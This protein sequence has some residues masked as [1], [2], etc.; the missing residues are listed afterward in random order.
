MTHCGCNFPISDRAMS[1][2]LT[3][4]APA[5]ASALLRPIGTSDTLEAIRMSMVLLNTT[6]RNMSFNTETQLL[7]WLPILLLRV[8]PSYVVTP[9]AKENNAVNMASESDV[10]AAAMTAVLELLAKHTVS[11]RVLLNERLPTE[12][13]TRLEQAVALSRAERLV[14]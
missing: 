13:R 1:M 8:A 11:M 12:W 2:L 9:N 10:H 7:T 6:T 5:L 14:R 3:D 4:M